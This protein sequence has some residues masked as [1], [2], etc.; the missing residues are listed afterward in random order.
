MELLSVIRRWWHRDHF[1]IREISRRTGLSRNTVRRYL[2]SDGIEPRFKI[3][4]RPSKL[5]PYADKLSHML[6]QE[7]GKSRK[8]KRT[9]KQLC[10]DLKALGYEGSYN[11]V[12]AF[13][14]DWK[15]ARQR[16][17][18][19]AGRGAYVPLAFQPGEVFQFDWSED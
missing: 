4:D 19:T 6:R 18:Q 3:A 11:R 9:I 5:D 8:Q 10:A 15:A 1:S 7:A 17:Q 2:R 13:A 16:E 14:R 12:A